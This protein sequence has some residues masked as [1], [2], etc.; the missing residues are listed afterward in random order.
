[1]ASYE[2]FFHLWLLKQLCRA[3]QRFD[4]RGGDMLCVSACAAAAAAAA[5]A[6][7]AAAVV[8][9]APISITFFRFFLSFFLGLVQPFVFTFGTRG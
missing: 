1:M 3:L 6:A 2:F 7:M 9:R 8:A 5:A 4:A